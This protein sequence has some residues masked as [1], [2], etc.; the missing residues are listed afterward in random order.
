MKIVLQVQLNIDGNIGTQGGD[1]T[2]RKEEDI[3]HLAYQWIK[4]I[5]METG[6]RK[7]IILKVTWNADN[8]ITDLVRQL[9][10]APIPDIDLPF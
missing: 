8:D 3:P 2:V 5:K 7:T 9:D 4:H 10:A 1:F 6:H